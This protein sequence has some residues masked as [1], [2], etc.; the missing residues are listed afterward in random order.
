MV[1]SLQVRYSGNFSPVQSD[2]PPPLPPKLKNK[3]T[4]YPSISV[5]NTLID[6]ISEV[7]KQ[8]ITMRKPSKNLETSQE[9]KHLINK[10]VQVDSGNQRELLKFKKI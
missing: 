5:L 6:N 8:N 1:I 9:K 2:I 7:I 10:R 3:F 4:K